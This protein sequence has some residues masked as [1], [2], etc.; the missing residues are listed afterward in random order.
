MRPTRSF[1]DARTLA[2]TALLIALGA[3]LGIV[4]GSVVPPL[5]VPGVRIGLANIA[6]VLALALLGPGPAL[7]VGLGRVLI[8]ALASGTLG[9]PTF[10]MA[11]FG[12]LAAWGVMTALARVAP[13]VSP[14][15]WSVAGAAAH[16]LVQL[17]VAAVLL[18]TVAPMLMAPLSLALALAC[19][20]AVGYSARLLLSRLPVAVVEV[21]K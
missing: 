1:A 5:P 4:E 13:A 11:I 18:G 16:V 17:V 14:L 19:G 10:A 15:G 3:M 9:G 2:S 20:L 21:G 8:V 12:A 6:V 7:Q